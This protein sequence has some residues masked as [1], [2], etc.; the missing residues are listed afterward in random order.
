MTE[1]VRR[2]PFTNIIA[3]DLEPFSSELEIYKEN[4][5]KHATRMRELR[6]AIS[7][8]EIQ[9]AKWLKLAEDSRLEIEDIRPKHAAAVAAI[10]LLEDEGD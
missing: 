10:R 8:A 4:R 2:L 6:L 9:S 1:N 5:L 3:D 7:N